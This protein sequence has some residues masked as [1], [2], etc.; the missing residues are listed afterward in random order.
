MS[1]SRRFAIGGIGGLLPVIV[2]FLSYD[3][4][5]VIDNL[6]ILSI[7]I[8]VGYI[9]KIVILFVLG[10]VFASFSDETTKPIAL[11][12]IGIA[13]PAIITTYINGSG[14]V[15][16]KPA[17][18]STAAL[19]VSFISEARA[20]DLSQHEAILR[21]DFLG[22]VVQGMT[23]PLPAIQRQW[24]IKQSEKP[25]KPETPPRTP[26]PQPTTDSSEPNTPPK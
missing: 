7:G 21:V 10:G 12:Q 14:I 15:G 22:D 20:A 23:K 3:L 1:T 2:G 26:A 25:E 5:P 19:S 18:P 8:L 17:G 11:L 4:G 24:Q 16:P 13:A 9:I 6:Y